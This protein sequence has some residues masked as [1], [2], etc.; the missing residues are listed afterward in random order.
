MSKGAEYSSNKEN[1]DDPTIVSER[2]ELAD[3]PGLQRK[4]QNRHIQ[5]IAIGGVIGTGLFLRTAQTLA[6]GGPAGLFLG[7]LTFSSVCISVMLALG[8]LVIF[9]PVPGG[10]ITLAGRFVDPALSFAVV[11]FIN[12]LGPRAFGECEFWFASIK[13]VTIIGLIILGL[14]IDLGGAPDRDRR[15]F[16]YWRD[17]GPFTQFLQITGAKGRFLSFWSTLIQAA[18][19]FLGTEIVSLTTAETKNPT[20]TLPKAIR[21]VWIRV[22]LFYIIGMIVPSDNPNLTTGTGNARSSA[23]VIAIQISGIKVLPSIINACILTSAW[24]AASSDL[25][26][27]SRALY[28]LAKTGKA[29]KIFAKTNRYGTPWTSLT[30]C[31]SIGLLAYMAVSSDAS[32]VFGWFANMASTAGIVNWISLCVTSIRH[33]IDTKAQGISTDILPY[34]SRFQPYVAYYGLVWSIVIMLF[35]NWQIFLRGQWDQ[36]SFVTNY[37]GIP[38][39]LVYVMSC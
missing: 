39:F 31:S 5:M 6:T 3:G 21:G 12:F 36:A 23:W 27:S 19:S 26:I 1:Q 7:Y 8:E 10:H 38:F 37:F 2:D 28:S 16:R 18:Y 9:L 22:I 14:I 33:Q 4:L 25:Y 11:V 30:A 15:G 13:V 24:S 35:A 34:R 29:P 20:K 17:P 32:D